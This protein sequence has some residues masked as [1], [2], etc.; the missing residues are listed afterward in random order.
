MKRIFAFLLTL[1]LLLTAMPVAFAEFTDGSAIQADYREAVQAMSD[2]KIIAGFEDGSFKPAD[3]LT[4]AQAAKIICSILVGA[5]KVDAITATSSFTDVPAGHWAAKFIGYCAE[6]GIVGGV[7]GGKFNPNG[8]LTSG[9]FA[10]MLLV[11]FGHDAEKEGFLGGGWLANVQKA[12]QSGKLDAKVTVDDK[13]IARQAACQ[14]AYNF[15]SKD[16][17][18]APEGYEKTTVSFADGKQYR[19]LGRAWQDQGGVVCDWTADGVEFTAD[20]AGDLA[21]SVNTTY[22][23]SKN[24]TTFRAIVDGKVGEQL[25]L[26]K[27]GDCTETLYT[28]IEAGTHTIRIVKDYEVSQSK[29]TIVSITL[30]CK[31]DSVKATAA[32]KQLVVFIGD[33]DTAGFGLNKTNT[34]S[35]TDNSASAALSY[36][37]LTADLLDVDYE[38][39]GKRSAGFMREA[40][41]P[42]QYNY[43]GFFEY[44]NPWRDPSSKYAFQRKADAVVLKVSGNDK[45]YSAEE[46]K[47]SI[48]KFLKVIRGVY[49]EQV[50]I[51]LFFTESTQ[52]RPVAEAMVKEHTELKGVLVTYN[53]DGMGNHSTPEA[54]KGYAAKLVE[55]LKPILG[56]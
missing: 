31:P 47:T 42:K 27:K 9:A 13:P 53:R 6:K 44:Q 33:S 36:G 17:S 19:L 30:T 40:G 1:A 15:L 4:R 46:E 45:S 50:P 12:M 22:T 41:A 37:Y 8:K 43:F 18:D 2:K 24:R 21:L 16:E 10:K 51:V 49:G 23:D 38:I 5:D 34:P 29:D 39:V 32:K 55:T 52:H 56:K 25:V 26:T 11:A 3:T 48:E 7:G 35:V 54:H 20:C 14:M 28:G